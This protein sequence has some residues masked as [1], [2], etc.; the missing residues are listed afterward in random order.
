MSWPRWF[1]RTA[2]FLLL[3]ASTG[4]A[5]PQVK[6]NLDL[7]FDALAEEE[8][9]EDAPEVVSFYST[10]LEGD[11][12]F[13]VVDQS[14]SMLDSGELQRAKTEL[15]KNIGE[16]SNRVE[17]GIIFFA[18]N[19]VKFPGSGKPAEATEAMKQ[20]AKGFVNAQGRGRGSCPMTGLMDGL[21][22]ANRGK[23]RRKVLVYLGDGGGTCN[24]AGEADYLQKTVAT[25]TG[26]NYQRIK[27]NTIGVVE[28]SSIGENFLRR[29]AASNGGSYTRI[30]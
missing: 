27:I 20:A 16:F 10:N 15:N 23:A 29:L 22:L 28:V 12:F 9:E 21:R 25:I 8:E 30:R 1:A 5:W 2:P 6:E 17:F 11:G 14:G 19:T 24:G 4:T 3:L 13:Y 18:T 26:Q 7:P